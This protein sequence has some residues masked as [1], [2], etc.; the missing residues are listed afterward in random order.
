MS[1]Q[2]KTIQIIWGVLLFA[3][4]LVMF[5]TIPGKVRAYQDAGQ[6]I[7]GLRFGLYFVSV[8][9]MVGGGK[10]IFDYTKG[11]PKNDNGES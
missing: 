6:Y 11:T 10:K 5:I 9:L 2:K 8:F 3:A 4:G 1:D 7:F